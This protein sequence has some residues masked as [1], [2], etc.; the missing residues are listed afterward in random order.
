M[1]VVFVPDLIDETTASLAGIKL[2]GTVEAP[3]WLVGDVAV[4]VNDAWRDDHRG[5]TTFAERHCTDQ[6]AAASLVTV[7]DEVLGSP[8][9]GAAN[10]HFEAA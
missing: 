2:I 7:L 5:A 1:G 9:A 8:S 4:A 6:A 3:G 10:Q